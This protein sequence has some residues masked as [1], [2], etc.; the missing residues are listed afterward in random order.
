M[1]ARTIWRNN[2]VD[3]AYR[4]IKHRI[5]SGELGPDSQLKID[6][7]SRDLGVSSSPIREALRRLE[8]EKWV[9]VIP[10]RGAFVRPLDEAEVRELYEIREIIE[11]AALRKGVSH[12]KPA[13]IKALADALADIQD[14]LR[15]AEQAATATGGPNDR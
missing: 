11:L 15:N 6:V 2:F 13:S 9:A 14:A 10:Y 12:V 3:Q 5:V 1:A 7:L 4:A 8:H